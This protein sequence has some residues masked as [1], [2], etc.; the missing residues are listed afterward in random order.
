MK[1]R[2]AIPCH[3]HGTGHRALV[4]LNTTEGVLCVALEIHVIMHL[5]K[6]IECT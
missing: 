1:E 2:L 3:L 5:A 6:A 4:P